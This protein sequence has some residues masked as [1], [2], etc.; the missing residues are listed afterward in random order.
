MLDDVKRFNEILKKYD[1]CFEEDEKKGGRIKTSL[2]TDGDIN[3]MPI[4][5]RLSI[6]VGEARKL[7]ELY[8]KIREAVDKDYECV[9]M[10]DEEIKVFNMFLEI[11]YKGV[12]FYD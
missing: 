5:A 9:E 2:L 6:F 4:L 8:K 3:N 12:D 7:I 1:D 10:T 11:D